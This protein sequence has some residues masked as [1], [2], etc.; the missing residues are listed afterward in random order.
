MRGDVVTAPERRFGALR[1]KVAEL[2]HSDRFAERLSEWAQWPPRQ[3]IN[4]LLS[5]L[6]SIDEK[7]KWRAVT[8][9]GIVVAELAHQNM[10]A[11]R[12]IMR[13]LIWSLNDESGGI[14]WGSAEAMGEIMARH[15]QLAEEY[16][17]I[18]ISY[19]CED[20]NRLEHGL[21]ECGALWGLGRLAGEKPHLVAGARACIFPYLHSQDPLQRGLAAWV[22][23]FLHPV[24]PA[25]TLLPLIDDHSEITIYDRET[26]CRYR[27]SE[28]ASRTAQALG[29]DAET[30][31]RSEGETGPS[32]SNGRI[33]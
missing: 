16:H 27:L 23:G 29:E 7:V 11:A 31:R 3:V 17:R 30:R 4:P 12:T 22:L 25:N 21:L 6:F 28:L 24:L 14:G 20:G 5:F 32:V 10:E 33:L 1:R 9:V 13:R 15:D 8:A 26:L 19:I 18:L 2:L